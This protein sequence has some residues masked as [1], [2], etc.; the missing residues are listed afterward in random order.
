MRRP[1]PFLARDQPTRIGLPALSAR[2]ADHCPKPCRGPVRDE[3]SRHHSRPEVRRA[4]FAGIAA[5][6]SHAVTRPRRASGRRLRGAGAGAAASGAS[7]DPRLQPGD[8][9]G[10]ASWVARHACALPSEANAGPDRSSCRAPP[11]QSRRRGGA[12]ARPLGEVAGPVRRPPSD[13][14]Q[15]RGAGRRCDHDRCDAGRVRPGV[16]AQRRSGSPC[17]HGGASRDATA[18]TMSW[19]TAS[20]DCSPSTHTQ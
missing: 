10:R 17:A 18:P 2:T 11:P 14:G 12:C 3:P 16:E 6:S 8:R 5:C 20:F 15:V 9:L 13:R 1:P 7:A 4:S 19:A